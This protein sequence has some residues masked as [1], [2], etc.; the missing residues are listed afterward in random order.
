MRSNPTGRQ[1]RLGTEL[2]K[3]R[4]NAGLTATEAGQLLGS[5]QTLVSNIEAGRAGVS[6]ERVRALAGH[7]GCSDPALVEALAAMT[8]DRKRG[9]WEEYREILPSALLDLS[10]LEH[11]ARSLRDSTTA[12]IPGL[13]QTREYA[14]EIFRQAVT[15]LPPP[16][17]EHRLSFRIKRQAILFRGDNPTP[18]EA[19]IHEAAL[20]MKVGGSRVARQQ[21]QHLLDMSERDHITLRTITF[22]VGAYPGSGQ[23]I[24]YAYGPVPQLDTVQLDQSHG[25]TFLD[26]DAQLHKYRTLFDRVD[27]VALSPDKTRD[28][29]HDLMREL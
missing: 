20:R 1:L 8:G 25:V 14:L 3:L 29:I 19:I 27:A 16:D 2:R 13:L 24:F 9:W 17:I 23:S 4:E 5:K 6:P 18:Y 28:H 7:Y 11:H 15:E 26:A 22:G 10:E 21:L 12:R